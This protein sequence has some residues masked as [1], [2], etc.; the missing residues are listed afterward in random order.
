M[1]RLRDI[2]KYYR[3]G[4]EEIRALDGVDLDIAENEY[5]AIMGASGSGKSTLM[6]ILGCLDRPT[7]GTYELDGRLVSG[8][9]AAQLAQVRNERI[10]FVF[11]SFELLPRA[12]AIRNVELPLIYSPD[13]WWS[14]RKRA[15]EALERVGLGSRM[16]HRPNQLSG[17]QRQRVAIARALVN[18]PKIL[19]ADEPT[20]NLDSRT[21]AEI[22][23]LF[24]E[25]HAAGQ[26]IILVTHE[27]DVARHAR[28]IV[29]MKDGRVQS[30]LPAE[31]DL[32]ASAPMSTGEDDPGDSAGR[33]DDAAAAPAG[34][35]P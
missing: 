9:S 4:V 26:T 35:R 5:V 22:L 6:N 15:I 16:H 2:R 28:R 3:V 11:Q 14:R 10:G 24:D 29:R 19:L 25:L 21:S 12:T 20:G 32:V 7:S 34:V 17:G 18:R 30:D 27:A 8:M 31:K 1:L 33:R 13:G 23:R